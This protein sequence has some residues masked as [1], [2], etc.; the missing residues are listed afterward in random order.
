MGSL[1][2][3]VVVEI[4]EIVW[5]L[6]Q[7]LEIETDLIITGPTLSNTATAHSIQFLASLEYLLKSTDLNIEPKL[8]TS[9]Q[10]REKVQVNKRVSRN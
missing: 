1:L 10:I 5:D 6:L 8:L 2:I 3:T 4:R 9:Y 7:E